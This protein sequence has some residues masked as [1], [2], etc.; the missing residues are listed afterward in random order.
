MFEKIIYMSDKSCS[1]LSKNVSSNLMNLHLIF[2]DGKKT[3][4]GEVDDLDGSIVKVRFLGEIV[5]GKLLNGTIR[6]P[7]LD[8]RV[9]VIDKSEVPIITGTNNFGYIELGNSPFYDNLPIYM[10]VN[11]FFSNHFTIFGNTGSGKS[12]GVSRLF[13][14]MFCDP[15][16]KPINANILLFDSSSE[17]KNAF[18]NINSINPM[19]NYRY[20]TT[21]SGLNGGED[22]IIPIHLL[23]VVDLALLLGVNKH[24]Q[25]PIIERMKKLALIF[26]QDEKDSLRF[27]NHLIAKAIMSVLYTSETTPNK[28][29]EIFN[30]L[31]SCSTDSFK[32]DTEV[33]GV[34]Y[35][36]KFRDLFLID[37]KGQFSESVLLGEYLSSFI[38]DKLEDYKINEEVYYNLDT[39]EKALEFTLISEGW[40]RNKNTYSDAITIKVRL[41]ELIRGNNAKYFNYPNYVSIGNYLLGLLSNNGKKYQII[42]INLDDVD[43]SFAKVIVKIFSRLVFDYSKS[44]NKR[45][46]IPFHIVLEEAHRY[47]QNDIDRELFGFNIFERVAKEGRKYG[48]LLGLI[49]QRPVELSDTVISQCSNFLIFRI[50]HPVDVEYIRKMVPNITDE[51]VEKQKGLQ[52]GTC[53]AFGHA[54]TIPIIAKLQMPNPL[55]WSGN[56]DVVSIWNSGNN[57]N[58]VVPNNTNPVLNNVTVNNTNPV[59]NN[60]TVNNTNQVDNNP[61]IKELSNEVINNSGNNSGGFIDI[62]TLQT[63]SNSSN[64]LYEDINLDDDDK[65]SPDDY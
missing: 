10:N 30:I 46:S 12:C 45:A 19:Y 24:S 62:P 59:L 52:S 1:I 22:L 35:T 5:N 37:N 54:F 41:H 44:L 57:M 31:S 15:K 60:V 36:R 3:I 63:S 8:A 21:N 50:N 18:S 51:I 6:K 16:L 55:P 14:N 65:L 56:C 40:L 48:V 38:D 27:K 42:N 26:S 25:L 47:V 64:N 33:K 2:E 23:N 61:Y 7:S 13:Q 4:L 17:Y 39:L 43:D 32:L 34:G 58:N 49:T 53:L 11:A 29:N 28:K 20:I 9:R